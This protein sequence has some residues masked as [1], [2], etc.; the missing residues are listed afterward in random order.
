[1]YCQLEHLGDCLPGHIR[2][3]LDELPVMLDGTYERTLQEIKET[4]WEFARQLLQY[5][6]MIL[7]PL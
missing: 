3:A 1:V 5:V 4:N 2:H 6:T 7:H